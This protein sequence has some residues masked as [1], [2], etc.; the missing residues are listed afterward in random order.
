MITMFQKDPSFSPLLNM[1]W[2]I[3]KALSV[4]CWLCG[5]PVTLHYCCVGSNAFAYLKKKKNYSELCI[6][7]LISAPEIKTSPS[8]S[9][10]L[11]R[12]ISLS[13]LFLRRRCSW[14]TGSE[15]VVLFHVS[16]SLQA[17]Q[18]SAPLC[19]GLTF[20]A[21]SFLKGSHC[22][23]QFPENIPRARLRMC[24]PQLPSQFQ[25]NRGHFLLQVYKEWVS[26][27]YAWLLW[28][29]AKSKTPAA[30]LWGN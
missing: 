3:G 8:V 17:E 16:S 25:E 15:A 13:S 19:T 22:R 6:N 20:E 2:D 30:A 11:A 12:F 27:F 7:E 23:W 5:V 18:V 14:F 1:P 28:R 24:K 4:R 21:P 9:Q 10:D 26:F 29:D